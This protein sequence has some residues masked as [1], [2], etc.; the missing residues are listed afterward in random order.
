VSGKQVLKVRS[1]EVER[2]STVGSGDSLV[3]GVAVAL[4]RGDTLDDGLR[5]GTAAGAATAMSPGTALGTAEDVAILLPRVQIEA[6][7]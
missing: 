1:P 6:I 2:R 3:A 4:A 5:L 7:A